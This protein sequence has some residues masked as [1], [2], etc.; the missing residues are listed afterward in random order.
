VEATG[1]WLAQVPTAD[2]WQC[3]AM[4]HAFADMARLLEAEARWHRH[5]ATAWFHAAACFRAYTR[6]WEAAG[7]ASRWDADYRRDGEEASARAAE[8]ADGASLAL[9]PQWIEKLLDAA[10]R[11]AL[12]EALAMLEAG[13]PADL[14]QQAGRRLLAHYCQVQ[15]ETGTA[16]RLHPSQPGIS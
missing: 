15:G 9:Q 6:A 13:Y 10:P 16:E 12:P 7:A 2:H 14:L 4:A 11:Q 5:A 8:L 3:L 1:D